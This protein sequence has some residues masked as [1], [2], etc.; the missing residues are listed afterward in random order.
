M[1]H[2]NNIVKLVTICSVMF[3]LTA[4][5][6]ASGYIFDW[7]PFTVEESL[8]S[9]S[10]DDKPFIKD[11]SLSDFNISVADNLYHVDLFSDDTG[12][13]SDQKSEKR[14]WME[15]IRI[16]FSPAYSND[17]RYKIY[18]DSDEEQMSKFI[19]AISALIYDDS[20]IKSLETLGKVVGP[21]IR[22]YFEF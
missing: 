1:K 9:D 13:S 12:I 7:Q 20:R 19:D 3:I 8:V 16:N 11:S 5:V 17:D 21:Q 14:S 18:A 6:H 22:F 4:P 2:I 15:N 10:A